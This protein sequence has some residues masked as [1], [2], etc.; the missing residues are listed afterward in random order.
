VHK[1]GLM[2]FALDVLGKIWDSPHPMIRATKTPAQFSAACALLLACAMVAGCASFPDSL[3]DV[4]QDFTHP[5]KHLIQNRP[6]P[7]TSN[8]LF[9]AS[10]RAGQGGLPPANL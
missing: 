5:T 9:A 8:D 3:Q 10:P 4:Q 1:S 2:P 6:A 7:S